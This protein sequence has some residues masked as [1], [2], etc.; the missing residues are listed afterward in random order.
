MNRQGIQ[1]RSRHSF[2]DILGHA[3]LLWENIGGEQLPRVSERL[4]A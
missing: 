2:V 1:L 3:R 4:R